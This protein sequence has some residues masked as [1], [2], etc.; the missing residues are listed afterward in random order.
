MCVLGAGGGEEGGGGR[1]EGMQVVDL[2]KNYLLI[3]W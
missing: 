3:V 1:V 2:F